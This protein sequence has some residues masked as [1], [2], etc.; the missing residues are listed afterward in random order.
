MKLILITS[1]LIIFGLHDATAQS[2]Q[3][4]Y[5][6]VNLLQDIYARKLSGAVIGE[7]GVG[8]AAK[9]AGIRS[10]DLIVR[11][12]D[13]EIKAPEDMVRVIPEAS[14]GKETPVVIVRNGVQ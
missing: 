2:Q 11:F 9:D 6:G 4:A 3:S 7:V 8:T 10:G 13:K 1:I 14:V 12:D 5:L